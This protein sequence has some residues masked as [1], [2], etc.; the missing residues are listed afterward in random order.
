MTDGNCDFFDLLGSQTP[1]VCT[2]NTIKLKA[3]PFK[4]SSSKDCSKITYAPQCG[5]NATIKV[6]PSVIDKWKGWTV[7]CPPVG[8]QVDAVLHKQSTL[9]EKY[10]D[11]KFD[12]SI[13]QFFEWESKSWTFSDPVTGKQVFSLSANSKYKPW[14][15]LVP[16]LDFCYRPEKDGPNPPKWAPAYSEHSC[17]KLDMKDLEDDRS[18]EG[19]VYT[20]DQPTPF[21]PRE[22]MASLLEH[23]TT[24]YSDVK[25]KVR[26]LSGSYNLQKVS[27][28]ETFQTWIAVQEVNEERTG[29]G[30]FPFMMFR[31][32]FGFEGQ[33]EGGG[34]DAQLSITSETLPYPPEEVCVRNV[35]GWKP[36][37]SIDIEKGAFPGPGKPYKLAKDFDSDCKYKLTFH[38]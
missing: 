25:D 18:L 27:F 19:S 30:I 36:L 37:P 26:Q 13:I 12:L 22:M 11:K 1:T 28:K 31:W 23:V 20:S 38:S 16:R 14:S 34:S 10:D 9:P 3:L 15:E 17:R 6:E 35:P 24:N 33:V 5:G 7:E 32:S 21:V 8:L 4:E 29:D 2:R